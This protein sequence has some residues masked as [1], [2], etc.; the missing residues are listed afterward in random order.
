MSKDYYEILGVNKSANKDEIKKAFHK[1]AHQ[2]HPD[3][4]GGDEAKFKEV[5]E[6]YQVLSNDQKRSQ[7][8]QFGQAGFG[9][10]QA[11]GGQGFGGFS[12]FGG[13]GV[14]FDMNDI[15]SEFFGGGM[16]GQRQHRQAQGRDI[17]VDTTITLAEAMNGV[18]KTIVVYRDSACTTCKATGGDQ[19]SPSKKCATCNGAG[20]VTKMQQTILGNIQ[21]QATCDVC[22][23]G[24]MVFEKSCRVCHGRGVV[25]EEKKLTVAIPAGIDS[26]Q[27]IRVSGEGE[28]IRQGAPGDLLITVHVKEDNRFRREG[29]HLY[30]TVPVPISTAVLGGSVAVETVDDS[31]LALKIPAGTQSGKVFRVAG[32][33]VGMVGSGRKGDLLVTAQILTPEKLSRKQ[34][35]L[36]Q[37]LE[38]EGL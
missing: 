4:Q 23:G 35:K 14:E 10:G 15:F 17:Q 32:K 6:A 12:G 16:R 9:G 27:M 28:A 5:N 38:Q 7:Y 33:G 31:S 2:F 21:T 29:P 3:K 13:Q 37:E 11:N 36:F 1:K 22:Q 18:K 24:G 26:G 19:S 34:K 25:K 20:T 8:D 30:T